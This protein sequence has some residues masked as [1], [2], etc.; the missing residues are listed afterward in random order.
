MPQRSVL[1]GFD[2]YGLLV[3]PGQGEPEGASLAL[4]A[5]DADLAAV[6]RH[7][8]LA[9]GGTQSGRVVL[10]FPA[11]PQGAKL[12]EDLLL[13][14]LRDSCALV[15][16][17][18]PYPRRR[19]ELTMPIDEAPEGAVIWSGRPLQP[20]LAL[21]PPIEDVV[22]RVESILNL[23]P[24]RLAGG[25]RTKIDAWNRC[26]FSTLAVEWL[27]FPVYKVSRV[28]NKARRSV[29]RWLSEGLVLQQSH[30]SFRNRLAE[31]RREYPQSEVLENE[32]SSTPP[33]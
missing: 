30:E 14:L 31:F 18:D 17:S 19:F 28:L 27:G 15:P 33:L 8:K 12:V 1:K 4:L 9:E 6:G 20:E 26:L 5:V 10:L 11:Y 22:S 24:G 13:E 21:R 25:T 32:D 23:P 7:G 16:D 29:S 3:L 2:I